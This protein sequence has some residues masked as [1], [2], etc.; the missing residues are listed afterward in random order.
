MLEY[1][2]CR[3]LGQKYRK[4]R[5]LMPKKKKGNKFLS[6]SARKRDGETK[7]ILIVWPFNGPTCTNMFEAHAHG[8]FKV[9]ALIL[10]FSKHQV[11][12]E[13]TQNTNAK[14]ELSQAPT[15]QLCHIT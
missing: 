14:Y 8:I 12:E 9:G 5:M 2:F 10:K 3:C 15:E 7:I 1:V 13:A 4:R 6:A 11:R